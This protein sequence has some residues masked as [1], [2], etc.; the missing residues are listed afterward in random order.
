M[1]VKNLKMKMNSDNFVKLIAFYFP[2]LHA[3]PENDEWWGKGFTDWVKVKQARAMF[4]DHYQPR[5]PLNS[6]Y[7]DQS[8][9]D[10][11][12]WQID[13][14]RSY[15]LYGFC[16][17]HYWFD[18][19]HLLEKPTNIF[20]ESK[21]LDFRFCLAWAN[22]TWSRRWDGLD[23]HILIKQTHIPDK[24]KWRAHFNYLIRAWSDE[25]AI[26]IDERPVFLIYRAHRISQIGDMFDFWQE[27]AVRRG[28]KG[29]F[30]IAIKQYEFPIPD[31]LKYF[32]AVVQFQPFEAIYSPEF[33]GKG[34]AESK[35]VQSLRVLPENILDILRS[36]KY[37]LFNSL[38]FYDYDIVWEQILKKK[39]EGGLPTYPG[40]FVDW[41]N[42][43]RYEKRAKV[44]RRA[45]PEK[46][47]YWFNRLVRNMAPQLGSD[48]YIF[49]NAWNEWAESAYL[50]PDERY[51][52]SYLEAT[53]RCLHSAPS[54]KNIGQRAMLK[55]SK[56][57]G[58]NICQDL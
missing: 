54:N 1:G 13:L 56:Y 55:E 14:A 57:N 23:H 43:A 52:Y 46:F 40:A 37:S 9:E 39:H 21:D 47:E 2:Q 31:V 34:L 35:L 42:T 27:L 10:V 17:Y 22:E 30:F 50:E 5:V 58:S 41:D 25:R 36:V 32:D 16:H 7:Y 53:M 11:I 49:I 38:T 6:R 20:L 26:C 44:F 51:K 19:K 15:G 48:Q 24:E 8:K 18:G 12:R 29:I 45:C 4:K 33:E 28:L 3:I